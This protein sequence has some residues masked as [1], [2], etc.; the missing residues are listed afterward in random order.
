MHIFDYLHPKDFNA[1]RHSCR[2]WMR[3][4]LN[5]GLLTTMLSRGGWSYRVEAGPAKLKGSST[6]RLPSFRQSEEWML[7]RYLARQC[8]LASEWTGNGLDIMCATSENSQIDFAEFANGHTA[9]TGDQSAGL[10]FSTS[11]CGRFV[12]AARDTLIIVYSCW[13]PSLTP[14]TSVVCPRRV[15]SMS[16]D[17]SCGHHAVA[18]LLEGRMGMVSEL[19]YICDAEHASQAESCSRRSESKPCTEFRAAAIPSRVGDYYERMQ[20]SAQTS[21]ELRRSSPHLTGRSMDSFSSIDVRSYQQGLCLRDVDDKRTHDQNLINQSWNLNIHGLPH[22]HKLSNQEANESCSHCIPIEC[23]ISTFYRHLCSEDD[24]PRSVA[25]CPQR[26][27]VAFGC[28]AGIELHWVDALTGQSV[29]RQFPLTAPS[30]HL[31]FLAPRPGFESAKKLRL[32][33]SAGHPDDRLAITRNFFLCRPTLNSFWGSLGFESNTRRS[34]CDHYHAIPLS[35]GHHVLF[36][37]PASNK[38]VLGCDAP[39]GGLT[40]LLRKVILEPPEDSARPRLYAA[41]TDFSQGARI[42]TAYGDTIVLYSIPPNILALSQSEQKAET[43][44]PS[45]ASMSVTSEFGTN[46]WLNWWDGPSLSIPSSCSSQNNTSIWPIA[47]RGTGIGTLKAVSALAI[48]TRPD[49]SI[50]AFSHASQGRCWSLRNYVDPVAWSQRYVCHKGVVHDAYSCDDTGDVIMRDTTSSSPAYS[51]FS[52]HVDGEHDEY[53]R[54]ERSVVLGFDGHASGVMKRMPK[55]LAVENDNWVD[56]V[57]VRGC[58]EAWYDGDGD[59]VM[60]YGT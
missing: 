37:D 19:H 54:T 32:I 22:D 23:G 48:Q 1:A 39:L 2:S 60:F 33:S 17:V 38:L 6:A 4:S 9:S 3:A 56:L 47:L 13:G 11:I 20:S 16:M 5:K 24:P 52:L 14:V 8:A 59:V 43:M 29:S 58:S 42:V 50:W 46:H 31:F 28:S 44:G 34:H 26:R 57:D 35:D 27:C 7:S 30:D 12:L 15:L 51:D 45:T 10:V 40:K 21:C 53:L 55:A 49:I 25:I 36:V 18:A 41:A